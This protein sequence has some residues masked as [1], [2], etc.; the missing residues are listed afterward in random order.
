MKPIILVT[1][2]VHLVLS[3][4]VHPTNLKA[5][6]VIRG[7]TGND[8]S[9]LVTL[10]ETDGLVT[11]EGS[12]S[13]LTPSGKHGFHIHEFGDCSAADFTSAG[14][15][16]N[17]LGK[18]HGAPGDEERHAGDL[19]NIDADANGEAT[20]DIVDR[21]I[22]LN[23]SSEFSVIGRAVIVHEQEDDLGRGDSA[24]SKTTGNAGAR[25]A[26]GVIGI[27]KGE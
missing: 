14:S 5:I 11:L 13:G 4:S 20:I 15:H 22:S 21:I 26:C 16:F 12:L 9:G 19:G 10:E 2:L 23:P 3:G 24:D 17:P 1:V 18:E 7:N 6:V 25:V 27:A 8:I